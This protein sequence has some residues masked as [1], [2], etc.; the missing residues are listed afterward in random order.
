MPAAQ[1]HTAGARARTAPATSYQVGTRTRTYIFSSYIA[2]KCG[3]TLFYSHDG[4]LEGNTA[5]G[6]LEIGTNTHR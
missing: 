1:S 6:I 5:G 4:T 3:E 2:D